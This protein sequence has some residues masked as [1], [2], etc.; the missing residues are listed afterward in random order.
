MILAAL[1]S[2]DLAVVASTLSV[3]EIL[4]KS[5]RPNFHPL[6]PLAGHSRVGHDH[7]VHYLKLIAADLDLVELI[8]N[9]T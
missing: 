7:K 8:A 9:R 3:Y 4:A 6:A 1:P 5:K 2:S